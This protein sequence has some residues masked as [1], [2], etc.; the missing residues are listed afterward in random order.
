MALSLTS[1]IWPVPCSSGPMTKYIP[2]LPLA[3]CLLTLHVA[4]LQAAQTT[5]VDESRFAFRHYRV[6]DQQVGVESLKSAVALRASPE[7]STQTLT[8]IVEE[9]AARLAEKNEQWML[10]A[11]PVSLMAK[12][13]LFL[14]T[15]QHEASNEMLAKLAKELSE[16]PSVMAVYPVLSRVT[17]RAFYDEHMSVTAEPGQL[18]PVLETVLAKT[19]GTLV[20]QSVIPNTALIRVGESFRMDAVDASAALVNI[21]SLVSADPVLYRELEVTATVNDPRHSDQWHL[22][23]TQSMGIPGDGQIYAHD[24]WDLTKGSPDVII[25]VF[26]SGTDITHEDLAPNIVNGLDAVDG[27]D[28]PSPECSQSQDGNGEAASCP[29]WAPYRESHGTAV[30]GTIAARGDNNIGLTGVCP[31]CS[32]YPGRILGSGAQSG[33]STAE[34]FVIAVNNGAWIINNSW[35]PGASVFFPLGQSMR[36][37]FQYAASD[38]RDGKG[39]LIFFAAGNETT[40]VGVNGYAN[41]EWTIAVAASTN[42]DDFAVYSN[43]GDE[44]DMAAPSRGGAVSQDDYGIATT[45]VPGEEGYDPSDYAPGF[46]GTSAASPVAAGVAGLVLSRNP[47]LTAEQVRVIMTSTADKIIANKVNWEN[48]FGQSLEEVFGYADDGHSIG[49]GWG[50]VNAGKAV[51]VAADFGQMGAACS[52]DNLC[53]VCNDNDRCEIECTVQSDCPDGT[54]CGANNSCEM[55]APRKT[56][57]GQPCHSDCPYCLP[58]VD[59]EFNETN[60]CTEICEEDT[61]CPQGFDCRLLEAGGDRVCAVGSTSAGDPLQFWNC[62]SP[63][64]GASIVVEGED[65]QQYCADSCFVDGLAD[66]PYGFHCA[67][68]VCECEVE[69]PWGCFQYRCE[70][71]RFQQNQGFGPMCFPNA[72]FGVECAIDDDCKLGDYCTA[73]GSCRVD[74]RDGCLTCRQ[75]QTRAD[76]GENARCFLPEG[77]E[78]GACTS[79]CNNDADCGGTSVCGPVETRWGTVNMCVSPSG[80]RP[81]DE[82][83]TQDFVCEVACRDDV[84]CPSG[85]RCES[86]A[87]E[88]LPEGFCDESIFCEAGE[89]CVE[90]SCQR[91]DI[92]Q[93]PSSAEGEDGTLSPFG[94]NVESCGCQ[95]S[96]SPSALWGL[97]LFGL[98]TRQRKRSRRQKSAG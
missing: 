14:V 24:A 59:S 93:R 96:N 21:P 19:K 29:N 78:Y 74:D 87:C 32:L 98:F 67:A 27:D 83:C 84:P 3:L 42:L 36:T 41:S 77:E 64:Y 31:L 54:R 97:L 58:A 15:F 69:S 76:C 50:R 48:V 43:Y 7:T 35:G 13:G 1:G 2:S 55:P 85:E 60:I 90:N 22:F 20:R 65:E 25:A 80:D 8:A 57:S 63:W 56:K 82:I 46:G 68:S 88:A 81:L 23:R 47:D 52:H 38:G 6:A 28:D 66:C 17:G 72:G 10:L 89:E 49:F 26:D 94:Y 73:E 75:C 40:D 79:R 51:A 4:P 11:Q 33:F 9:T 39:T 18:A 37:A 34:A 45:D 5:G 71:D 70:E 92:V 95:A 44:I 61:D 12:H 16:S 62:Q 30:S 91:V 53:A 86:G